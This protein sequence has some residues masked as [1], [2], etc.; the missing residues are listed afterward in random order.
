[1]RYVEIRGT[2]DA[3]NGIDND[4]CVRLIGVSNFLG[5][6]IYVHDSS[7][8][9]MTQVGGSNNTLDH[10]AFWKNR[11][12]SGGHGQGIQDG[13]GS[14]SG[15][16]LSYNIFKDIEGQGAIASLNAGTADSY[17]IYGNLFYRCE[18][19]CN[20]RNGLTNGMITCINP[21]RVCSNWNVYDNTFVG[22]PNGNGVVLNDS[23][24]GSL[25]VRD[26]L[27]FGNTGTTTLNLG[28]SSTEDYNSFLNG[29]V[30]GNSGAHDVVAASGSA[31]P[32]TSWP[33]D[34]GV[35]SLASD[36]L[37][38]NNRIALGSP[39]DTDAAG[40]VLATDRGAYQFESLG[41]R[42]APPSGLSAIVN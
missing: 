14:A 2:G 42:P 8:V 9:S 38:W 31:D 13:P 29:P 25:N 27:W 5:F 41:P 22:N 1:M 16:T 23:S 19:N 39:F 6:H 26:N 20:N 18:N 4:Q 17:R 33:A 15:L 32:F 30:S 28:G 3:A 36:G 21:G 11:D 40:N 12:S 10:S 7:A 24:T 34:P 37:S 35:F